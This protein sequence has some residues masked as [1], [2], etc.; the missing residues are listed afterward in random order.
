MVYTETDRE[1]FVLEA[2]LEDASADPVP[3]LSPFEALKDL[4]KS[5]YDE[6][7]GAGLYN[8][9]PFPD[10]PESD[11][12]ESD[13]EVSEE[14]PDD[15]MEVYAL[16]GTAYPGTISTIYLDYFSGI[17]D[18]LGFNEH[19]VAYR[20]SQYVYVMA[21][22]EGL[23]YNGV[24]FKGSALDYCRINT[25]TGSGSQPTVS[26]GKDTV[27]LSAG[28]AFVYSDL[29]NFAALTEGGTRVEFWA[30]LFAIGFT[31]VYNVCHD[32]FDYIMEHVY[33]R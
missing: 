33:R 20:E 13:P 24:Q 19:Y 17:V 30:V 27:N 28:T 10:E 12:L 26:Y 14:A 23:E 2:P 18:K 8:T 4:I 15:L 3:D 1:A 29:G 5:V 31:V 25:Y 22:D 16:S 21:W 9:A 7:A 11:D 32:I 6:E